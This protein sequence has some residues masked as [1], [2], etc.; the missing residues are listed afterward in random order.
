MK[1]VHK[2]WDQ[3]SYTNVTTKQKSTPIPVIQAKA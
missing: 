2:V 1:N 3:I